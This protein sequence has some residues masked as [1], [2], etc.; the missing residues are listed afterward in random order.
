[1]HESRDGRRVVLPLALLL[2]IGAPCASAQGVSDTAVAS[3][4]QADRDFNAASRARGLDGWMSFLAPDAVRLRLFKSQFVRGP[5]AIREADA[6]IFADSTTELQWWPVDGGIWQDGRHAYTAGR[7]R[8]L[9][10]RNGQPT[11]IDSGGYVTVWRRDAQ[12]WKVILDT[13]ASDP[14]AP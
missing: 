4:M 8:F 2:V 13:G 11:A 5:A 14:P 12:G 7:W 3:V 9:A 1:M 10:T 6:A